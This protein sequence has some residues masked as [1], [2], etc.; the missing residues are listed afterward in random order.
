MV[1][2]SS[3]PST[4]ASVSPSDLWEAEKNGASLFLLTHANSAQQISLRPAGPWLMNA[5]VKL[6][7]SCV[8]SSPNTHS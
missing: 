7:E 1:D 5:W 3:L 8:R 2:A 4:P 6:C